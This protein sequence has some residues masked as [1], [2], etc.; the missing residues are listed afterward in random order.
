MDSELEKLVESGKLTTTQAAHLEQLRPGTFCLHKSWGF[1]RV[2]EWNLLLNQIVIDF[3]G[4]PK[5]PMQL[6]YAADHLTSIPPEHFLARKANEPDTIRALL[7]SDPSAVV[8]NILEG[9]G[10]K[11]M[12]NQI[13]EMMVGDLFTEA[14][15]K[16][17]WTN[18]KKAMKGSGYFSV[19]AKKS[20][21]IALRQD[22]VSRADELTAF[23]NNARQPK[24]QAAA[25]D[26]IIKFSS[27]FSDAVAQ[28]QPIVEKI[29]NTAAQNQKLHTALSFELLLGRDDLLERVPQLRTTRPDLALDR[30]IREEETRLG[31]ILSSLPAAKER[32]ILQ[33]LPRALGENWTARAWQLMSSHNPRTVAQVPKVFLENGRRDDL[34]DLLE[35]AV[36]E[37][38]ATSEMM[39]WLC[40]ER[41]HWPELI[42]P[43]ILPAV[44]SSIERDQHNETSR[45]TR[46]RDLLLD[47]RELISDLFAG[48]DAGAARDAMRRL[49]LTPVFDD[50]TKR[51]FMARVIKLYP[52]LES[53]VPGAQEEKS[54]SLVVSWS[55][56][57]KRKAEYEEIINKKIPENS[58]EIGVARSY[59]DLRENFEFKAAK[60]M[61]AVLMR[62]KAELEHMLTNA[63]A[64]DFANPDTSQV[65]IGTIVTLRDVDSAQEE[66][67]TILGAWDGNPE[68]HII[69]YQ[70]AIGQALLGK[71]AGERVTL[72]TEHG[73]ATFEILSIEAAPVDLL[74]GPADDQPAD[75]DMGA[76]VSAAAEVRLPA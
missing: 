13:S 2:A 15:W 68:Q 69:S 50:L 24:E 51:S 43:E 65:S 70:T 46:L 44:L 54:E 9:F 4:K 64:T 1:G 57:E 22:R 33:A 10:G 55:S 8:R 61:Q 17:W 49:L 45:S 7:K 47:D 18:A 28:L 76:P 73:V 41:A 14:E 66:S 40:R 32:R 60:Q 38:S 31:S 3:T 36:R 48:A 71:R 29:E 5:H 16:K 21:P 63:R 19:P 27:E 37:H 23:F 59:G 74:H 72:S 58:R 53:M 25:L 20:E 52:E 12:L 26:Q 35:R 42:S 6:A 34:R 30:L 67:Y 11:A 39:I 62:R 56:L 75:D